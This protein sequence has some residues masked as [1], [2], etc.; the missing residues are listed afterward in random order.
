MSA[1]GRASLVS[2]LVVFATFANSVIA[3]GEGYS[4]SVAI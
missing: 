4:D 2:A 3:Q 1:T